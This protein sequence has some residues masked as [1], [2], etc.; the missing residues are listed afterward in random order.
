VLACRNLFGS[1]GTPFFVQ[2]ILFQHHVCVPAEEAVHVGA[3]EVAFLLDGAIVLS[4]RLIENDPNPL[5]WRE[6]CGAHEL[7]YTTLLRRTTSHP[8]AYFNIPCL[9]GSH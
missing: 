6:L 3:V 2:C 4:I 1:G 9:I 5:A 7:D 8:I